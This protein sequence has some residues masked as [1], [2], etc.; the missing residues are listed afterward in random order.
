M[1]ASPAPYSDFP[2]AFR[3]AVLRPG[4]HGYDTARVLYQGRAADEGPALIAR[5]VDEH[6]V[7]TVLRYASDRG[8]SRGRTRRRAR[9]GR[10]TRC[11]AA[12]SSSTSRR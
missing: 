7:A 5:C 9:L 8:H 10:G 12:P 6:D 11:P 2:A 4:D 1:S 3:G